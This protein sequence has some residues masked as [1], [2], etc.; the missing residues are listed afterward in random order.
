MKRHFVTIKD[1]ARELGISVATVS[2]ALRDTYDVNQDTRQLVLDKAVEM[3]YKPNFNA[4][5]LVT[6]SSHNIGIVLPSITNYYFSTVITGVQ[7]VAYKKGYNIV[8]YITN[9]SAER[10]KDIL[11]ELSLGNIDGLLVCVSSGPEQYDH[12]EQIIADG[13]PIVFFDRVASG[14]KASRV[15]QDDYEGAYQ[16]VQHLI[17]QGYKKIAHIAG[18]AGLL[19]TEKRMEGFLAA[20]NDHHIPVRK[21]WIIHSGF[22]RDFG[23]KDA[24]Q[25]EKCRVKPD[26]IFAVNDSKAIGAMVA[27]KKKKVQI[28]KQIGIIGFTND[29]MCE[30]ISPSLTTVEEPALEVGRKSCEFLLNHINKKNFPLQELTLP[31]RLVVRESTSRK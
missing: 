12:F 14:I 18:P 17:R 6:N 22:S 10:E 27:L 16:A 31:T 3:N 4:T 5:A 8:L 24:L 7:E 2:R 21:E 9:D 25:L 13:I 19:F 23:G 29:P 26:A 30:I 20:L 28:G 1:I 15:M 11:K